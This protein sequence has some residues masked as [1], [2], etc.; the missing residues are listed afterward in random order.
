M[1]GFEFSEFVFD[2]VQINLM[3]P[4]ALFLNDL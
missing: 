4:I 1:P 3:K 2:W